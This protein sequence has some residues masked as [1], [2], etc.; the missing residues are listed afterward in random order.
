MDDQRL[1]LLHGAEDLLN[2]VAK[3]AREGRSDALLT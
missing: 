2:E 1:H 3:L